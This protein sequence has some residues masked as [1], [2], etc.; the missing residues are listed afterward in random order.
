MRV[1]NGSTGWGSVLHGLIHMR[2]CEM[3]T[4]G[5]AIR[6]GVTF[7]VIF[8][9]F[10]MEDASDNGPQFWQL[11][12]KVFVLG[13]LPLYCL[14]KGGERLRSELKEGT[15]EYLWTRPTGKAPLF[16]GFF[17]SSLLGVAAFTGTC[18]LAICSAGY[19]VGA[20]ESFGQVVLF[21]I[22]CSLVA[23]SFSAV[24]AALGAFTSKFI[25]FGILY[26]SFV[27]SLLGQMPTKARN[28]SL[29]THVESL[30]AP[31][32]RG[33]STLLTMGTAQAV[34]WVGGITLVA[35]VAGAALF[36]TKNYVVGG[37]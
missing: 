16:F 6:L 7:C 15:I 4:R 34:L 17:L 8:G 26:F 23:V 37:E 9:L 33:A 30:L 13:F 24:A 10:A 32:G 18:V 25:V 2:I 1:A 5:S 27:E 14:V 12:V 11:V 36:T 3:K 20:I 35:L 22:G 29:I 28:L 31:L 19:F 21:A